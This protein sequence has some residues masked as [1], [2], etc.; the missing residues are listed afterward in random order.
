MRCLKQTALVMLIFVQAAVAAPQKMKS[1]DLSNMIIQ[2]E[3]RLRVREGAPEPH[4]TPDLYKDM[5]TVINDESLLLGFQ[6]AAVSEPPIVYA[7]K[8]AGRKTASAWLDSILEPPVLTLNIKSK[9]SAKQVEWVF[10]I[11]NSQGSEIYRIK[12]KG[13]MPEKIEWDGFDSKRQPLQ[14]GADYSYSLS[15]IDEAG[16]PQHVP[17]KPFQVEAFRI[18]SGGKNATLLGLRAIFQGDSELKFSKNG[19]ATLTEVKDH[20]RTFYGKKLEVV[21]YDDDGKFGVARAQAIQNFLVKEL[22]W[23]A[24]KTVARSAPIKDGQGYS[25]VEIIAK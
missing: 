2:G 6:P 25:H 13:V 15:I 22:D 18:N 24:S 14:M 16:N 1:D 12:K 9:P 5:A 23:A 17:G 8:V 21:V 19:I 4:F 3:N 7:S 11:K 10:L 20:L